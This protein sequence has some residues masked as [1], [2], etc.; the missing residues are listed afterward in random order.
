MLAAQL[1]Q[2]TP[3]DGGTGS[4]L[5]WAN[6]KYSWF[7][8]SGLVNSQHLINDGLTSACANHGGTTWTYNQGVILA[9]FADLFRITGTTS[10]LTT[11]EGIANAATATLVDRNGSLQEPCE[12][13]NS[14]GGDGPQFKGIFV[15]DLY[16]LYDTDHNAAY[17][18]FLSKNAQAIWNNDRDTTTNQL[19]LK[20]AGPLTTPSAVT[21]DSAL[22]DFDAIAQFTNGSQNVLEGGSGV[23]AA[24]PAGQ[25]TQLH[26]LGLAVNGKQTNQTFTVQ[27]AD[28]ST[29]TAHLSLSDWFAVSVQPGEEWAA[30]QAYRYTPSARQYGPIHVYDYTIPLDGAKTVSSL[31]LPNNSNVKVLAAT[32]SR[33]G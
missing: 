5:D 26:I 27:Y 22:L 28:N 33:S 25:Y 7:A 32:L 6:Q 12:A 31:T 17:W 8:G 4:Y 3:G 13:N 18:S 30:A 2:R 1:H 10:Y 16:F 29:T 19:G 14:C 11:A 24:L 15:R 21:V 20:W 23:T 9:G